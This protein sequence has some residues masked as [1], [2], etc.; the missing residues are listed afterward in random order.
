[1]E[2]FVPRLEMLYERR[3][4]GC[5]EA[6][7]RLGCSGRAIQSFPPYIFNQ[8]EVQAPTQGVREGST[9]GSPLVSSAFLV[10]AVRCQHS[11]GL[12]PAQVSVSRDSVH[13]DHRDPSPRVLECSVLADNELDQGSS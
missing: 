4:E 3:R 7:V 12:Q 11:L 1:M 6:C 13:H 10:E 8:I 9:P 2:G 5:F